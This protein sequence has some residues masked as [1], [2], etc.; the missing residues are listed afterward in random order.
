[1][2]TLV[3]TVVLCSFYDVSDFVK[4]ICFSERELELDIVHFYAA[5]RVLCF[6]KC[7]LSLELIY[8]TCL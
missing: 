8:R 2:L 5:F 3:D 6:K 1:M 7:H 4:L